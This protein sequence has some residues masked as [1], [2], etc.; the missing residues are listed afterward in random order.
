VK[1][2]V[3]IESSGDG[4][5][6]T[7]LSEDALLEKLAEDARDRPVGDPAP[8]ILETMPSETDPSYWGESILI[9]EGRIVCPK[10]IDVVKEYTFQE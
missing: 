7:Q 9:V 8:K 1:N 5:Y 3:V 6:I 4:Q 2:Y 10:A